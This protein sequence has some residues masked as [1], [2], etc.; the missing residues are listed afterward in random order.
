MAVLPEAGFVRLKQ[1][2]GDPKS[3]TPALL[4]I[5]R[6]SWWAGVKSGRYPRGHK[7]GPKT[8]AWK[9]EDIRRILE[10]VA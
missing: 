1:I 5:G 2:I 10:N 7:L 8:T 4:P 3:G 6:S 9:V